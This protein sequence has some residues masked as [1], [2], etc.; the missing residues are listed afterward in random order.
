MKCLFNLIFICYF[1][2]IKWLVFKILKS[3]C[4]ISF[5][6]IVPSR[7]NRWE[8]NSNLNRVSLWKTIYF[9]FRSLSFSEAKK[10]PI[11]IYTHTKIISSSGRIEFKDCPLSFGII[12]WGRFNSFRSKGPTSINNQGLI[13]FH[14][15]GNFLKGSEISVFENGVLELGV[16][17]FIG[18][19]A[20]VYAQ[21]RIIFDRYVRVSYECDICDSDFHYILNIK[22]NTIS[23]KKQEIFIGAF[24]WIGNRTTIKKG[25]R[26]P[27]HTMVASA[28]AV[29]SKDYTKLISPFSVLGGCPARLIKSNVSRIWFDEMNTIEK[30][31]EK[32]KDKD[33]IQVSEENSIRYIRD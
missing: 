3:I 11:H 30:I 13:V 22:D 9:N 17:F 8:I 18:E 2:I 23:P 7:F 16:G 24:N 14:G 25:T 27:H 5:Y 19:N 28:Y 1:P 21:E 26:T 6:T 12:K 33:Y 32:I 15:F 31:D 4:I 29:L 10:F 20:R